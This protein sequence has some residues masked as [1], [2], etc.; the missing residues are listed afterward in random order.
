MK[1]FGS[2]EWNQLTAVAECIEQRE[3]LVPLR[4]LRDLEVKTSVPGELVAVRLMKANCYR[5]LGQ[6]EP[7]LLECDQAKT[8]SRAKE[9]VVASSIV[10]AQVLGAFGMHQQALPIVDEA[11]DTHPDVDR[12]G[13]L[14]EKG[15]LPIWLSQEADAVRMLSEALRLSSDLEDQL[16]LHHLLGVAYSKL[17]DLSSAKLHLLEADNPQLRSA[18]RANNC[19]YLGIALLQ[20]RNFDEAA[21]TL[22]QAKHAFGP[23]NSPPVLYQALADVLDQL[24]RSAEAISFRRHI[25]AISQHRPN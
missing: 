4:K 9:D 7:A 1:C 16:A 23:E 25:S 8:L 3:Y 5:F 12:V 20:E 19:L 17:G 18:Y 6:C 11:L 13:V 2:E 24:G 15:N 22:L 10:K 21:R 14:L